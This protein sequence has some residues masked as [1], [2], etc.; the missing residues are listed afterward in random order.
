[1]TPAPW[2]FFF[3]MR[4]FSMASYLTQ[5]EMRFLRP[6]SDWM[7][8][9]EALMASGLRTMAKHANRQARVGS[10]AVK[11]PV[12][13]T[14][15]K[16]SGP[17]SLPTGILPFS[18]MRRRTPPTIPLG[19]SGTTPPTCSLTTSPRRDLSGPHLYQSTARNPSFRAMPGTLHRT[20]ISHDQSGGRR[21]E[22]TTGQTSK[23]R[24][25]IGRNF[26]GRR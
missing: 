8:R 14:P 4:S 10:M 3:A 16:K 7:L 2:R 12:C 5:A 18:T 11:M 25:G 19:L 1:M 20:M 6:F 9:K 26:C 23:R 22:C 17:R 13:F 24:A 15:R 21:A